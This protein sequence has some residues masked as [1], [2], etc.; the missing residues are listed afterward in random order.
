M[1]FCFSKVST[2]CLCSCPV[3]CA[4]LGVPVFR[5]VCE[6]CRVMYALRALAGYCELLCSMLRSVLLRCCAM[7]GCELGCVLRVEWAV[8]VLRALSS[9]LPCFMLCHVLCSGV[10]CYADLR[11]GVDAWSPRATCVALFGAALCSC[12]RRGCAR[13]VLSVLCVVRPQ[14]V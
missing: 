2:G 14:R 12:W 3:P 4:R 10:L 9:A 6:I 8:L 13:L 1:R 7:L 5:T 11:F